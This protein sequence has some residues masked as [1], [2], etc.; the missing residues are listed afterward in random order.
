M[1]IFIIAL[2]LSFNNGFMKMKDYSVDR[3]QTVMLEDQKQKLKVGTHSIALSLGSVIKADMD[4][5]QVYQIIRDA[6]ENIRFEKDKSGYYFVWEN[7][8]CIALPTKKELVGTDGGNLK[9]PNGKY[10][11]RELKDVAH[12]G[13]GYIEYVFPKPG[14]GDVPKLS[15]AEMIPGTDIWIGTGVYI[16][17]I[18]VAK[19]EI[20]TS[21]SSLA[22]SLNVRMII[23]FVLVLALIIVPLIIAI[24]TSIKGPIEQAI[25]TTNRV[26]KG[27]LEAQIDTNFDDEI[28]LLQNALSEMVNNLKDI[29]KTIIEGSDHISS[30]SQQLSATSEQISQ[31]ANEQASATEEVSSS[32]EEMTSNIQQ[33]TE[34]SKQT[35]IISNKAAQNIEAV[36]TAAKDSLDMVKVISEKINIINDI[37]FQTNILALNAAV[38]AARAGEHGKGFAVVAAEVRKL[39]ERSKVAA[40]EITDLSTR[41]LTSTEDAGKNLNSIVPEIQ[42]TSSLV[43]EISAASIEQNSGANQVNNAIQQLNNVTQQNAAAAEEMASSSEELNAQAEQLKDVISYFKIDGVKLRSGKND[44]YAPKVKS[45][46]KPTQITTKVKPAAK[47]APLVKKE[48]QKLK[49]FKNKEKPAP[50][51]P[52]P[53]KSDKGIDLNLG[54]DDSEYENF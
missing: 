13:G 5:E 15:Y 26:A 9:D 31:G 24:R 23:I 27:D 48:E 14:V 21:I 17:N 49:E 40:D 12:Q 30:A 42:K 39:A 6:V 1:A 47:T 43:Q 2:F 50:P 20:E 22:R 45:V 38:E 37:A 18:E 33:N 19:Q 25:K 41:T 10:F 54:G 51:K 53:P 28:G 52:T 34:N 44:L 4:K 3:T 46:A 8:K 29:I 32:M 36:G 7:T 11:I 16:D 35:E